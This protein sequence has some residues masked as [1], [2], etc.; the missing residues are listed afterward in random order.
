MSGTKT[1]PTGS[2]TLASGSF[3]TAA[4]GLNSGSATFYVQPGSLAQGSNTLTVTYTPDSSSSSTYASSTG[5][6][7]M[8]ITSPGSTNATVTIDTLGNRHLISPYIYG[9]NSTTETDITNL[10]PGFVRFGGN[11]ATNYNWK[12]FTYNAGGDWYYEDFGL[13]DSNGNAVDSVALTQ[14]TV[15]SGRDVYKRQ[16]RSQ[17]H[18]V[19][20]LFRRDIE[21]NPCTYILVR[22]HLC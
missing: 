19:S 16:V 5:T 9:I 12:L 7:N 11:E 15:N 22:T 10:S 18:V 13:G 17:I 21:F 2:V 3:A 1:T 4:V 14:Y 8:T 6:A 20:R